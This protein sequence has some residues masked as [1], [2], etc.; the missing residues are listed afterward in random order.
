MKQSR[1]YS[2]ATLCNSISKNPVY[3]NLK[4]YRTIVEE[5]LAGNV[6]PLQ[7]IG[8]SPGIGKSYI[9]REECAKIGIA[10]TFINPTNPSS[11]NKELFQFRN[12]PV[13]VMDDCDSLATAP[14][15]A[16][17]VK[18]GWGIDRIIHWATVEGNKN[19]RKKK[20]KFDPLIPP[21]E[22]KIT[23]KLI[24]LSNLNF[25]TQ[26]KNISPDMRMSFEAICSRGGDPLWISGTDT[27]LFRYTVWLGT[28][29]DMFRRSHNDV[30]RKASQEAVN[31][32]VTNRNHLRELS[33]RTLSRVARVIHDVAPK[34]KNIILSKFLNGQ[35]RDIPGFN[36]LVL[37]GKEWK[38]N[39]GLHEMCDV[40]CYQVFT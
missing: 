24:W 19:W 12:K 7:F 9:L 39:G 40:V 13:I 37:T 21:R 6:E 25:T 28:I 20:T 5:V 33:P 34:N 4:V 2:F 38:E 17:I 23:T 31:W 26:L 14:K 10:P 22:Y 32:F 16:S 3:K 1:P 27:E 15:V 36:E 11:F 8:G 29:G 35:T 30:G 18:M